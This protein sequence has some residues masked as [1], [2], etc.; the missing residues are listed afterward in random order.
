[1]SVNVHLV[2]AITPKKDPI[3]LSL[4][5]SSPLLQMGKMTIYELG[6]SRGKKDDKLTK[7]KPFFYQLSFQHNYTRG[8][9]FSLS[10]RQKWASYLE[11]EKVHLAHTLQCYNGNNFSAMN[12]APE[13]LLMNM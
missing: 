7:M 3:H 2:L 10:W 4:K 12:N 8:P 6:R 11:Q 5:F 9:N 1:M 13:S